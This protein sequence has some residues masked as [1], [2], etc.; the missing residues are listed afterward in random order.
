MEYVDIYSYYPNNPDEGRAPRIYPANYAASGSN[1]GYPRININKLD[2][3]NGSGDLF[4]PISAKRGDSYNASQFAMGGGRFSF[5]KPG[6]KGWRSLTSER[7]LVKFQTNFTE[8]FEGINILRTVMRMQDGEGNLLYS[9]DDYHELLYIIMMECASLAPY[10]MD[11]KHDKTAPDLPHLYESITY[12]LRSSDNYAMITVDPRITWAAVQHEVPIQHFTPNPISKKPG[13]W[14]Y[15]ETAMLKSAKT[16]A[17]KRALKGALQKAFD[18][19]TTRAG[20]KL[21]PG[22]IN[23]RLQSRRVSGMNLTAELGG[24]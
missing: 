14:K 24:F 6:M 9:K 16:G 19:A 5:D 10:Q 12:I 7:R 18:T 20:R 4:M 11:E 23:R 3:S 8:F 17:L 2:Y 1:K 21:T 22:E 15:I 13:Q